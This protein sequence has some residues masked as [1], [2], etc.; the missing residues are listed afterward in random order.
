MNWLRMSPNPLQ[1]GMTLFEMILAMMMLIIFT[2]S[3]A[4]VMQFTTTFMAESDRE[5]VEKS[6]CDADIDPE[7]CSKGLLIDHANL[8]I[9]MDQLVDIL[10]Q[11]AV[12]AKSNSVLIGLI[13]THC[14]LKRKS[15]GPG[16]QKQLVQDAET[17]SRQPRPTGGKRGRGGPRGGDLLRDL[18]E[19]ARLAARVQA[20]ATVDATPSRHIKFKTFLDCFRMV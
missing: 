8:Q 5:L 18:H 19:E 2:G 17:E 1:V 13:N 15:N 4:M 16:T 10:V 3:V 14:T 12:D 11:P 6:G 7:T 9:A 20:G